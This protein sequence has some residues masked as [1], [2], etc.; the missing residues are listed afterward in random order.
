MKKLTRILS[1][2]IAL[3]ISTLVGVACE[4][5]SELPDQNSSHIH[6][7]VKKVNFA[8]YKKSDA[9]CLEKA[10]YYYSCECGEAG[11]GTF[12]VGEVSGHIYVGGKCKWCNKT[13]NQE[14]NSNDTTPS[15]HTHVFNKKI[16][17]N[18]LPAKFFK[19]LNFY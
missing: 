1:L 15:E 9:T 3:C 18:L 5:T 14:S 19:F 16:A 8:R 13:K 12:E 6:S 10:L 2:T 17:R 4:Q 11:E 7:Y